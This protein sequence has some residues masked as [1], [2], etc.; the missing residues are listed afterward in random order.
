MRIEEGD[1]GGEREEKVKGRE[2]RKEMDHK[3][4]GDDCASPASQ[5]C[6]G[7]E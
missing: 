7:T 6:S 4:D 5:S 3:C 2:G 1:R